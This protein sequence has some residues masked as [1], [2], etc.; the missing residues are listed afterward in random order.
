MDYYLLLWLPG[1]MHKREMNN[2]SLPITTTRGFEA[3]RQGRRK[4]LCIKSDMKYEHRIRNNLISGN[5]SW[6]C[7]WRY[8]Y[9]SY[10]A[11]I[12]YFTASVIP[13][14]H[15]TSPIYCATSSSS[16]I[17]SVKDASSI[18]PL[19]YHQRGEGERWLKGKGKD[20][21]GSHHHHH[22][23]RYHIVLKLPS[24]G[25]RMEP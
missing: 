17:T 18:L 14:H 13:H 5:K 25:A 19:W 1:W 20:I 8:L 21:S 24:I 3:D 9:D 6:R 7:V 10:M 11:L 2:K 22:A 16:V 12:L 4:Q 15:L 23:D